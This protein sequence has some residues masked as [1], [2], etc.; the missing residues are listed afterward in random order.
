M[1]PTQFDP[2]QFK[3]HQRTFWDTTSPAWETWDN[4]FERGAA[5]V[6]AWMLDVAGVRPGQ[7]VLDVATGHGEPAL[8]ALRAVGPTGRVVGVD[9]SPAMLEVARQRAKELDNI[10]F[11]EGD[12]ESLG[13]E[14]DSFDVV[15]SRFGLMFVV[16][17]AAAFRELASVLAPG[18][19]LAISV[20]GPPSEHLLSIGP[21]ALFQRLELPPPPPDQP[22]PFSMSD[23]RQL[24]EE[25]TAAGFTD[26]SAVER[27][28]PFRFRSVDDYVQF[29]KDFLP[30]EMLRTVAERFGSRDAPEAWDTVAQAAEKHVDDEGGVP[31]PS[32]ALCV[33][34]ALP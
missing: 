9:I 6:T 24:T 17:H 31:L 19:V 13:L 2:A 5:S 12:V 18:G 34:A 1:A 33:R 28:L 14:P 29:N 8:S 30:P 3:T 32:T 11:V 16:D 10:E 20:W 22:G 15:L 23:P 7:R 4:E 26:V 27:V 21:M 25:L